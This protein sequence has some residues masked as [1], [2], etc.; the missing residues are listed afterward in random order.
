MFNGHIN[1][2][3]KTPLAELISTLGLVEKTKTGY[4][5]AISQSL[6]SSRKIKKILDSIL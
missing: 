1:H 6:D 3:L 5:E 2:E 4:E